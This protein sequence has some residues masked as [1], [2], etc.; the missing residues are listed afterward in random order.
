MAR[1]DAKAERSGR[2]LISRREVLTRGLVGAAG[3]AL[4]PSVLAACGRS[5]ATPTA[6]PTPRPTGTPAPSPSPTPGD[7]L[8]R[9]LSGDLSVASFYSDEPTLAAIKAI[10]AGFAAATGVT[11]AL[12]V[13]EHGTCADVSPFSSCVGTPWDVVSWYS[14]YRMRRFA[15]TGLLTPIDDVWSLVKDNFPLGLAATVTG[16]DGHV[17]GIPTVYYPWLFFY[18]RSVWESKGYE[19]PSTWDDFL[20]LCA[21][22]KKDG[23]TPIAFADKDG[24][25]AMAIFDILDL[26]LNGYDFHMGLLRGENKWT[27]PRV[28]SVFEAWREVAAYCPAASTSRPWQT[29]ADSLARKQAGMFYF[30][31]FMKS[32]IQAVDPTGSAWADLE[33]FPFPYFG[34][35]FDG[36][37]AVEAPVDVWMI[38]AKSQTLAADLDNARAYLEYWAQGSTQVQLAIAYSSI[39]AASGADLSHIDAL[40]AKGAPFVAEAQRVSQFMDRDTRPDFAGSQFMQIFLMRFIENPHQ[41]LAAMQVSIQD[42]WDGLPPY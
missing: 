32:E 2:Q 15:A 40:L 25:P 10:D 18:R 34:N 7:F 1:E 28:T 27:D 26:R 23:L 3:L 11:P 22:M 29:A 36:E 37:K 35:S 17:Y 12:V 38:G 19:V 6:T 9:R 42:S 24:W 5:S 30:G 20:A 41:D 21:R 4:L 33:V 13:I 8:A 39:P 14:G 31:T 16:A